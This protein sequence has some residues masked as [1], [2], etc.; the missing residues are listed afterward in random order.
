MAMNYFLC[1]G[2]GRTEPV[3]LT[4]KSSRTGLGEE[5]DRKR[6]ADKQKAVMAAMRSE[7]ASKRQR[8]EQ[9]WKQSLRAKLTSRET[10]RDLEQSQ[11]VCEQLDSAQVCFLSFLY[12]CYAM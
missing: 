3:P 9:E 11:K 2:V 5:A 10:E 6:K 1:L 8:H 7:M 12:C 4:V